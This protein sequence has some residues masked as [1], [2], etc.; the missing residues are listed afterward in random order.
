[1]KHNSANPREINGTKTPTFVVLVCDRGSRRP[2]TSAVLRKATSQNLDFPF[3]MTASAPKAADCRCSYKVSGAHNHSPALDP[4]AH[5]LHGRRTQ[6]Q[7]DL[8]QY[9]AKYR[10][11]PAMEMA[12]VMRDQSTTPTFFRNRDVWND[13]QRIRAAALRGLTLTQ[14][15]I[16]VLRD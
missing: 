9:V 16:Q 5:A 12:Q 2:S 14:A 6:E 4:S 15:W 13:R 7:R 10:G 1:M 3:K 11:L 8:E